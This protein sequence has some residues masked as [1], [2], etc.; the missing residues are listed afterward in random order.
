MHHVP[1]GA[2]VLSGSQGNFQLLPN[3]NAFLGWGAQPFFFEHH[4]PSGAPVLHASFYNPTGSTT[5]Y[6]ARK[7]NW[8]AVPAHDPALWSFSYDGSTATTFYVSWNGAT[9]VQTWR[10][11]MS[12]SGIE[13]PWRRV[14]EARKRGFE[15]VLRWD[16]FARWAFAEAVDGEGTVLRRSGVVEVFVPSE[17]LRQACDLAGCVEIPR[18]GAEDWSAFEV[19]GSRM[20]EEGFGSDYTFDGKSHYLPKPA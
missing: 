9:T 14:G 15:T 17:A 20:Q 16:G 8:T 10:V 6:K 3:G 2:P 11:C 1:N 7:Y 5:N 18:V 4:V 19:S 13:G 12:D